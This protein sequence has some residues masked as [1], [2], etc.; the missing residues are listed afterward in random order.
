VGLENRPELVVEPLGLEIA[1]LLGDPFV[2][3]EVR[4][5][6]EFRNSLSPPENDRKDKPKVG[7]P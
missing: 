2:Q 1:L 4:R 5:D 3:P 6:E 7:N